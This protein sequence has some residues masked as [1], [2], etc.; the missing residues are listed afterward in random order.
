MSKSAIEEAR[1]VSERIIS[2][3]AKAKQPPR[4]QTRARKRKP[5]ENPAAGITTGE[6]QYSQKW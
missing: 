5:E 1:M 2:N 6:K 4:R 3:A